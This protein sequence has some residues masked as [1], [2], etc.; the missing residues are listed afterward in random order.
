MIVFMVLT[1]GFLLNLLVTRLYFKQAKVN[2]SGRIALSVMLLFT[3]IGHF[4][5]PEGMALMI[6]DFI[7][8]KIELIY[9]TGV[10]EIMAAIGLLVKKTRRLTGVLLIVFFIMILPANINATLH[11]LD[12]QTGTND[13]PGLSYLWYRIPF[14]LVLILWAYWFG[15]REVGK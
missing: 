4:K 13:G 15:V 9:L 7:P 2:L 14:Q 1:I 12:Y 6:P 3:A 11:H 10:I 5:F 8:Y